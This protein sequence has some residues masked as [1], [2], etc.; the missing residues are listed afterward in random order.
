MSDSEPDA[1]PQPKEKRKATEKQLAGLRKGMEALKTKRE[2]L[3]KEREEYEVKKAKG[4]VPVDAPK[5]KYVPNPKPPKV[6]KVVPEAPPPQVI[7]VERK[8]RTEKAKIEVNEVKSELAA[9]R[10]E[11]AAMKKPAEVV[12][13]EVE[14][15]VDRIVEKT[16]VLSGSELLNSIFFK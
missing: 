5:P 12:V 8:K 9:L 11:L 6:V 7:Q 16:K 2:A 4:D 3:A 1:P 14:K 13:K 15:P 10:T